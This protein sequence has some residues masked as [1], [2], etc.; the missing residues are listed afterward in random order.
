MKSKL[1]KLNELGELLKSGTITQDEFNILKTE[2]L[3]P[4]KQSEENPKLTELR[5]LLES[6]VITQEEFENLKGELLT[7]KVTK[8]ESNQVK[9][10]LKAESN[11]IINKKTPVDKP[12]A[13]NQKS[14]LN[15][16]QGKHNRIF[17]V[18]LVLF[19]VVFVFYKNCDSGS[20]NTIKTSFA[21]INEA[22]D[23]VHY[24]KYED[25]VKAWGEPSSL[26]EPYLQ[27]LNDGNIKAFVYVRWNNITVEGKPMEIRFE[28]ASND[29]NFRSDGSISTQP[30]Y[31]D[32]I[33]VDGTGYGWR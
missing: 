13:E 32:M 15:K 19:F 30:G 4:Q 10:D 20:G 12:L 9:K 28:N 1:D 2:L 5:E 18:S 26:G 23:Y 17:V 7:R 14:I 27:T 8:A 16:D 22:K 29:Y 21:T 3:N 11:Q 25:L 33:E 6:G 31:P 24:R